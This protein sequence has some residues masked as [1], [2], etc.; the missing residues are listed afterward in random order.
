MIFVEKMSRKN[1]FRS[2]IKAKLVYVEG[3]VWGTV[4]SFLDI[5]RRHCKLAL[6]HGGVF[7]PPE[8]R[9]AIRHEIECLRVE[10]DALL[11]N[12][13]ANEVLHD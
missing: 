9:E 4:Y 5:A 6:E 13:A 3:D 2:S 7:T 10:R 1:I 11:S 12:C 8:R